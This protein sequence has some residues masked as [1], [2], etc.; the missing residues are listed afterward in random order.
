MIV[1]LLIVGILAGLS[2][3]A[4]A[5]LAG[6]GLGWALLAYPACGTLGLVAAAAAMALR[7]SSPSSPSTPPAR[8]HAATEATRPERAT[9]AHG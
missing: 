6:A 2:G 4:V 7:P 8:G 1:G 9:P 5:L 3:T